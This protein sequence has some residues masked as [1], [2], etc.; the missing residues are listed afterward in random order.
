MAVAGG[1]QGLLAGHVASQKLTLQGISRPGT[2]SRTE[3]L[4]EI[5]INLPSR[6]AGSCSMSAPRCMR[7]MQSVSPVLAGADHR[8]T[9]G[10]LPVAAS[11]AKALRLGMGPSGE[12]TVLGRGPKL[13]D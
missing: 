5:P 12:A 9:K 8:V 2:N 3:A 1:L 6:V 10:R 4:P 13:V 11:W 7:T